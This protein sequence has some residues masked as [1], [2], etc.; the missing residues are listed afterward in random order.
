M[1]KYAVKK[2]PLLIEYFPER[3]KTQSMCYKVILENGAILMSIPDH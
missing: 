3:Y 1:C 2:L